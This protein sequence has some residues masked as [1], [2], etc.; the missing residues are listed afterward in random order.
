MINILSSFLFLLFIFLI[1]NG[2]GLIKLDVLVVDVFGLLINGLGFF[3][4][5]RLML[6]YFDCNYE[7]DNGK[8]IIIIW[9]LIIWIK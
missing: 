7:N 5:G 1:F 6:L 9:I 4:L 3:V 2:V 8:I